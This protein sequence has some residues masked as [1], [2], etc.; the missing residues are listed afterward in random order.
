MKNLACALFVTITFACFHKQNNKK[1][2]KLYKPDNQE[3]QYI[4]RVD[5]SNPKKPRIW[6]PGVYIVAKFKGSSCQ[7]LISDEASGKNHNYIEIAVDDQTPLRIKLTGKI[8]VVQVAKNLPA[9]EHSVLICKDTE[10]NV[11]Y[12]DFLGIRCEQLL[13]LPAKASRK[14]EYF[15]DSITSGTGMDL[16]AIACD[17]GQ[18]YDQHNAYMSYGAQTSRNLHAQWQ[19]TALA[20]VGLVHSCCNMNVVMPKIYDK[21][22]LRNDSIAWKFKNYQPDVVTI[23]LGQNDGVQDS[24]LFCNTYVRFIQN[25]RSHYPKADIVCLTSPMAN[26]A[27]TSALKRYITSI[28]DFIN[29]TGDN[30]VYRYFFS[31]Q[32]HNGCGG[33][34]DLAEHVLIANELTAYIKQLERW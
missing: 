26:E 17:Q 33:H 8:N 11:G 9:G 15:G 10:S 24:S 30:R 28:T 5:F 12:I 18:W 6:A 3:I 31:K 14:I 1:E 7:M 27:L 34:P 32:Y 19:L 22:F 23:C 4:G 20:G 21:V 2:L 29:S 25:I 13:Q 16:S